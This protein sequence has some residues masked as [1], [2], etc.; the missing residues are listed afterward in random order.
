MCQLKVILLLAG[1]LVLG[2]SAP[3]VFSQQGMAKEQKL[4]DGTQ[5]LSTLINAF[6]N[7][8]EKARGQWRAIL[9]QEEL[10]EEEDYAEKEQNIVPDFF[11]AVDA[12]NRAGGGEEASE[13][14][15]FRGFPAKEQVNYGDFINGLIR[16]YGNEEARDQHTVSFPRAK[17]ESVGQARDQWSVGSIPQQEVAE[18]QAKDFNEIAAVIENLI[19]VFKDQESAMSKE[20]FWAIG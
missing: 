7:N 2:E 9:S 15:S 8:G 3:A 1:I 5:V 20:Q 10:A 13:Q 12:I 11:R 6:G 18:E 4:I 14:L 19:K 16:H 17:K